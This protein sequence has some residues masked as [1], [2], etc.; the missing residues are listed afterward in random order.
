M[1]H[2]P[3]FLYLK[4]IFFLPFSK[5]QDKDVTLKFTTSRQSLENTEVN[6]VTIIIN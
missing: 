1:G 2:T 6:Y 5:G 4:T 3:L